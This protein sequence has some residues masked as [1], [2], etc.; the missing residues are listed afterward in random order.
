MNQ[1]KIQESFYDV[2]IESIDDHD[3]CNQIS[4][5]ITDSLFQ[6]YSNDDML[7]KEKYLML[8]LNLRHPNNGRTLIERLRSGGD[9][10][11]DKLPLCSHTELYPE[12]WTNRIAKQKAKDLQKVSNSASIVKEQM[13]NSGYQGIIQCGRCKSRLTTY[14]EQQTRSADEPM[15]AFVLCLNC[16]HRWKR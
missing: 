8:I 16:S 4:Q 1:Q 3:E 10:P 6:I 15:T 14:Y 7:L 12:L 9:L 5:E 11:P 2:L 13:I